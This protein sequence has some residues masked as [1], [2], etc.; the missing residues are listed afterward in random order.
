MALRVTCAD[1]E[2]D[3]N[4]AQLEFHSVALVRRNVRLIDERKPMI[5]A[6]KSALKPSGRP[7]STEDLCDTDGRLLATLGVKPGRK[8]AQAADN[9]PER[10]EQMQCP[11]C[12]PRTA[13]RLPKT[14]TNEIS[15]AL[16]NLASSR[17]C[18]MLACRAV[19]NM[20][21]RLTGK[22]SRA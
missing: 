16:A 5:P 1:K 8:S 12:I 2:I 11:Q 9:M 6:P 4:R 21:T 14:Q 13:T 3:T 10:N 15:A 17:S 20:N 22:A 7:I 18:C 19:E